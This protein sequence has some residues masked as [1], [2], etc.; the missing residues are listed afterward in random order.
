MLAHRIVDAQAIIRH[1]RKE[2]TEKF[3]EFDPEPM[4]ED[5]D[6]AEDEVLLSPPL[7]SPPLPSPP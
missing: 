4:W 5:N 1:C 2:E 6:E 7:P 3:Y